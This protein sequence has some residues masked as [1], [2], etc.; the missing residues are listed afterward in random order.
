[1]YSG[2]LLRNVLLVYAGGIMGVVVILLVGIIQEGFG[3]YS[4]VGG[5]TPTLF[6]N[7]IFGLL[8]LIIPS[9]IYAFATLITVAYRE[10]NPYVL[11]ASA[12][13]FFLID[14]FHEELH[15]DT[16]VPIP[17]FDWLIMLVIALLM[18][19]LLFRRDLLRLPTRS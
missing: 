10:I 9:T 6:E 4:H 15:L 7:F 19:I 16:N 5:Y 18:N 12:A 14:L 8:G 17:Y 1:M 2:N 11:M 3:P 13:A